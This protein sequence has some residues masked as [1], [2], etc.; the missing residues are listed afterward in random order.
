MIS[1]DQMNDEIFRQIVGLIRP[2]MTE[3]VLDVGGCNNLTDAG[4]DKIPI[5][6]DSLETLSLGFDQCRQLTS[7]A[8]VNLSKK[9]PPNL[10]SLNLNFLPQKTWDGSWDPP[11]M[12][13]ILFTI[14]NKLAKSLVEV[15]ISTTLNSDSGDGVVALATNLPSGTKKFKLDLRAWPHF[16]GQYFVD[17]A[18]CLPLSLEELDVNTWAND[19]FEEE[20]LRLFADEILKLHHLTSCKVNTTCTD[21]SGLLKTRRLNLDQLRAYATSTSQS[22]Y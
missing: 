8:L 22:T 11:R 16:K 13:D 2:D 12:D 7:K 19:H 20:E 18:K 9:L 4:L 14:A 15:Q 21:K 1:L 10:T 6:P 3:V 17:M 5:L